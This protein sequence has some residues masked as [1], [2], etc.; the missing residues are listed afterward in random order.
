[1]H[2]QFTLTEPNCFNLILSGILEDQHAYPEFMGVVQKTFHLLVE[3]VQI[4][5][6]GK[7]LRAGPVDDCAITVR[8]LV[9]GFISLYLEQQFPGRVL[10]K[11]QLKNLLE[12]ALLMSKSGENTTR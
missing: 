10:E 5:Q 4:C 1:M 8:S 12:K 7:V 3:V 6:S 2:P 9:H 11:Y